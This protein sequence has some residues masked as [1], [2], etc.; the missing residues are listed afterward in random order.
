MS[1]K[2]N[3]PEKYFLSFAFR[4][5]LFP[6][7]VLQ[8]NKTQYIKSHD[9]EVSHETYL[10]SFLSVYQYGM[11]GEFLRFGVVAES[12]S[13]G[14]GICLTQPGHESVELLGK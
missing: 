2:G 8:M 13:G 9:S 1:G 7:H 10:F 6:L 12:A 11:R 5:R 14:C 3:N 4:D